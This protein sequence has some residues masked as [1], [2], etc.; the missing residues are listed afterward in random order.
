MQLLHEMNRLNT[1]V[2]VATHNNA[3][4]SRHPAHTLRLQEGSLIR[5]D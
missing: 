5:D 4:V 2:I 1:T 3:L